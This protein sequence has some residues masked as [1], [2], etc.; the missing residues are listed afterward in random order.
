MTTRREDNALAR[1]EAAG[2]GRLAMRA[3]IAGADARHAELDQDY[4]QRWPEPSRIPYPTAEHE[5][6]ERD[7]AV[8]SRRVAP[9]PVGLR[10]D[11]A[12]PPQTHVGGRSR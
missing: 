11:R 2:A 5:A 7:G 1:Q 3:R 6:V 10:H 4:Y 9:W 12:L 8:S